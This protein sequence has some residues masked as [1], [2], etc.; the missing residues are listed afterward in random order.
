MG[1]TS[2]PER[3]IRQAKV[4]QLFVAGRSYRAIADELHIDKDT[5]TA[6]IR[7]LTT[8][9][10]TWAANQRKQA[11]AFVT[12]TYQRVID[13]AWAG[14]DAECEREQAYLAGD[15]D[16]E[17]QVPDPDGGVHQERKPPPFKSLRVAWLNTIR[18]TTTAYAKIVGVDAPQRV[19]VSGKDGGALI[20]RQ[21]VGID[22]DEV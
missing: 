9:L 5:V 13:E 3:A 19:E 20:V 17:H 15:Y 10:D 1:R 12:A 22:P 21:Y 11:T 6:D 8:K 18:E 2:D 14:Y 4:L 16:R 7:S